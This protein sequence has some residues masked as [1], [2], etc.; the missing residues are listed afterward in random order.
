MNREN[1]RHPKHPL[2]PNLTS[3]TTRNLDD[4]RLKT[5]SKT[6]PKTSYKNL[7]SKKR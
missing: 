2:L 4:L 1:R 5:K 3:S 7:R 6:K